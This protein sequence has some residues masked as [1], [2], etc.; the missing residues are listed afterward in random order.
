MAKGSPPGKE[1]RHAREVGGSQRQFCSHLPFPGRLALPLG[2]LMC[3]PH[4]KVLHGRLAQGMDEPLLHSKGHGEGTNP[5]SLLPSTDSVV[6]S[7]WPPRRTVSFQSPACIG[8]SP[9]AQQQERSSVSSVP[10]KSRLSLNPSLF[11][12]LLR[13]FPSE[14]DSPLPSHL[15][16][17]PHPRSP[18]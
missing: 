11:L 15:I 3:S 14:A 12:T 10:R 2:T 16:R 9:T 8:S 17:P 13:V 1:E 6:H 4:E 7:N 5:T 18:N